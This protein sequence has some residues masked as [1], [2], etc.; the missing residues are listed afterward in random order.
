MNSIF[1]YKSINLPS[2]TTETRSLLSAWEF[3]KC[4]I[5]FTGQTPSLLSVTTSTLDKQQIC[6]MLNLKHSTNYTTTLG[7]DTM[8]LNKI[9]P[10]HHRTRRLSR[11]RDGR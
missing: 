4:F 11:G 8:T 7:K 2:Y 6:W 1:H 5:S 3:V 10:R 9:W